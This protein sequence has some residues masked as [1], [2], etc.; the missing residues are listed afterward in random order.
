MFARLNRRWLFLVIALAALA[1]VACGES[2]TATSRPTA[3]TEPTATP[4]P[5]TPTPASQQADARTAEEEEYIEAVRA[6]WSNF[7]DKAEDFRAVFSQV[8]SIKSRLFEALQDAGAGTAFESAL[9]PIEALTPPARFQDDHRLMVDTL[10]VQVDYD[11]D[12]GT[13]VENQDLSAFAIANATLAESG[14]LMASG[15]DPRVCRATQADDVEFQFCDL[16]SET[17]PGGDYGAQVYDTMTTFVASVFSRFVGFGPEFE[18]EDI[19]ATVSVIQ[20]EVTQIYS[21]ILGDLEGVDP[22]DEFAADHGIL[23]QYLKDGLAN[24]QLRS[25]AVESQD[26]ASYGSLSEEARAIYCGARLQLGAGELREI[27]RPA[28]VDLGGLCGGSGY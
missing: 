25:T 22:P 19:L 26:L 9:G 24:N 27:V 1:A 14:M 7:N 13:A 16:F 10:T 5:A 18:V 12:V 20:P 2:A 8:Y 4:V 3:T 15:L 23:I 17:V 28:F 21:D 11:H 6:G